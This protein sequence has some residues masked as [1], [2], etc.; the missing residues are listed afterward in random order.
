MAMRGSA[1]FSYRNGNSFLH[2]IPALIKI[3]LLVAIC[4][5]AFC[6]ENSFSTLD[7]FFSGKSFVCLCSCGILL[8]VL[9]VLSGFRLSSLIKM[10]FVIFYSLFIFIFRSWKFCDDGILCWDVEGLWFCGLYTVRFFVVA[11]SS[12]L[13]YET[14]SLL[15]IKSALEDVE[16]FFARIIP[17]LKKARFSFLLA[18]AMNF[19][20]EIFAL[21]SRVRI[22]SRSRSQKKINLIRFVQVINKETECLFSC[23]IRSGENKRKAILNRM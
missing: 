14:T 17:P 23:L 12:E 15:E 6:G 18:L 21:W 7:D 10:K 9:H 20:P 13:V 3:L 5:A 2:R 11:F 8:F 4:F 16:N 19:I 1:I 22:A